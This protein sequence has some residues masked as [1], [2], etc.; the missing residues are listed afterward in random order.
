MLVR[1]RVYQHLKIVCSMGERW[2]TTCKAKSYAWWRWIFDFAFFIRLL[3][4]FTVT[5]A[6]RS[7]AH[8]CAVY[9]ICL[10]FFAISTINSRTVLTFTATSLLKTFLI[11][12]TRAI[13]QATPFCLPSIF[14]FFPSFPSDDN[15][16]YPNEIACLMVTTPLFLS[17][18]I[19]RLFH[20]TVSL[21]FFAFS[22]LVTC[23]HA[24]M[25][26]DESNWHRWLT[27]SFPTPTIWPLIP[28]GLWI[29]FRHW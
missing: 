5:T 27:T 8:G 1:P 22:Y 16:A 25:T 6:T 15:T 28:I 13:V 11:R 12:M 29:F 24:V 10:M 17:V 18:L 9:N 7:A 3:R 21:Q 23:F 2:L 19:S 20:L 4:N 26:S 14:Y